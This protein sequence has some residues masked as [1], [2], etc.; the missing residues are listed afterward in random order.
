MRSGLYDLS[1][2]ALQRQLESLAVTLGRVP[3]F[4]AA[5]GIDEAVLLQTRLYPNMWPFW[6]QVNRAV[7]H[8]MSVSL[9]AGNEQPYAAGDMNSLSELTA[10]VESGHAFLGKLKPDAFDGPPDR[11]VVF[12]RP[13]GVVLKFKAADFLMGFALPN[14]FFHH[15]TAYAILRQM[16]MDLGKKDFLGNLPKLPS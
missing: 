11:E 13:A 5:R 6:L 15:T 8:A 7:F 10:L 12:R 14:F 9:L 16:G 4:I 3:D 2:P 1:V